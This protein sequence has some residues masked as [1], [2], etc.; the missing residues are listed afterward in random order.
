M[1]FLKCCSPARQHAFAL[2][3]HPPGSLFLVKEKMATMAS[4]VFLHKLYK[5]LFG[6]VQILCCLNWCECL[7]ANET[8][9]EFAFPYINAFFDAFF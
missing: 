7:V 2:C 9:H 1:A 6:D 5:F 8:S 4:F 3:I